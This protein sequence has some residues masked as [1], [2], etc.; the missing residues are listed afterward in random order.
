MIITYFFRKKNIFFS[1]ERVFNS[2]IRTFDNDVK[3]KSIYVLYDR[4]TFINLIKNIFFCYKNKGKINHITGDIYYSIFGLPSHSTILTFH[5]LG[6]ITNNRGIKRKILWLIWYYLPVKK[7]KHIT[8]I[9]NFT[10][11][12]LI[13]HTK[14]PSNKITVIY[15]PIGE[16]FIYTPGNFNIEKPIILQIGTR[17]NKNLER[18]IRALS[19]VSCH[20]R[21]IGNL[22]NL[23][24][25]LLNEYS[26]DYS[27]VYN[28][29]DKEIVSEYIQSDIVSFPSLYEG[30]GMPIIESQAIGRVVLTSSIEPLVE[31]SN[32]GAYMVDPLNENS[33]RNGFIELINDSSLRKHLIQKGLENVKN[34]TPKKIAKEYYELYKSL[35]KNS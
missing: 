30:F 3:T 10:K 13:K 29:S 35:E 18:V 17:E 11:E 9:S 15:N 32:K 5:D 27:N 2:I 33:I 26:I 14:C 4:I 24:V 1:I 12:Q 34:Y 8:C 28:L 23:Q 6:L 7:A 16:D 25:D 31:V 19:S 20:L 22:T 21:I